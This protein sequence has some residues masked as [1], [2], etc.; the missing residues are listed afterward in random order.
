[1]YDHKN[2]EKKWQKFWEENQT[3]K[4]ENTSDKP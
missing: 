1:M 3:F 4:T 2:I